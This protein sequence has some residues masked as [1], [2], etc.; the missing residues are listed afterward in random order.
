MKLTKSK[1][2]EIIKEEIKSM[3]SEGFEI[4]SET[5]KI[6]KSQISNQLG[7]KMGGEV[8][9]PTFDLRKSSQRGDSKFPSGNLKEK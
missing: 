4:G 5:D 3:L 1:L 7:D 2:K 8:D 6:K 9:K